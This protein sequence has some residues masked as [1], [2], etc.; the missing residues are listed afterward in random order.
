MRC[1]VC[2]Q[3][4]PAFDARTQPAEQVKC[5]DVLLE[6]AGAHG[7]GIPML[8]MFSVFSNPLVFFCWLVA[9][10]AGTVTIC[11]SRALLCL[12]LSRRM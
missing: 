6:F 9:L 5:W 11:S 4:K 10:S 2:S 12:A 7:C 3:S 1:M 8:K